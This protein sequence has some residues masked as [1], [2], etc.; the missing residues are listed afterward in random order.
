MVVARANWEHT[1]QQPA[2]GQRVPTCAARARETASPLI[3]SSIVSTPRR[4]PTFPKLR[5][6]IVGAS[7][8]ETAAAIRGS[9][10]EFEAFEATLA[11]A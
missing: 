4:F 7:E 9:D 10:A 1:P 8:E 11:N 3:E 2:A 6:V 5:A